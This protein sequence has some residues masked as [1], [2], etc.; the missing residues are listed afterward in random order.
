MS[1]IT[2]HQT[3]AGMGAVTTLTGNTGGAVG[4]N[5][6][7]NINVV[8]SGNIT[9]SGNP[10]TN[11]ETIT[12]VGT[13]NHAVQIGNSSGSLT[14]IAVGNNGQV[15]IGATGADPAFATLTSTGGTV[16]FTPGANT[17]NLEVTA[18]GALTLTGNSGTATESAGNINVLDSQGTAKFTGSGA[19]LTHTYSDVYNN[20]ALGVGSFN[21][22]HST[23]A[24]N[25]TIYGG[26]SGV[27]ISDG[28][29]NTL[30][31]E[32]CG[33]SITTG[34]YSTMIGYS[35]GLSTTTTGFSCIY[36]GYQAGFSLANESNVLR[37]G[38]GTGSSAGNLAKAFICGIDGVNVGSVAKVLTMASDQLGTATIT[39]GT[40]VSVGTSA[41]TIT[42]SATG[43]GAFA[44][45]VI[46][47]NQTA[48]VN[49][50][51]FCNKAGTLALALPA[52]S[53]VGDVIEVTNENTALGVQFTQA[54]GQQILFSTA[55]TTLGASGT[56]T[57]SAIGDTLK[58]VCKVANTI[59]RATSSV[60]NW[61]SA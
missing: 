16:T 42:I 33:S 10:G 21:N 29:D 47:A 8:G 41:N 39:A 36:V 55:S 6:S 2:S 44:W 51:Y 49:N 4:P 59:W 37:I 17:L 23:L 7:G 3:A 22:T 19:T 30:I 38:S 46:T 50:G 57:S 5:G 28:G 40:G 31:G 20:T 58:I 61:T 53:A 45:S 60:G 18:G 15:L 12:L 56:L 1:Q 32:G 26:F 11:T 48:A 27:A 54:S 9:V 43:A 13:T 52:T 34:S 14:S 25:N 24:Q 35:A